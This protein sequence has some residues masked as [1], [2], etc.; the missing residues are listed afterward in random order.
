M[1]WFGTHFLI[2]FGGGTALI[3][4]LSYRYEWLLN[5]SMTIAFASGLWAVLPD[6]KDPMAMCRP[7]K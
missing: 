5:W 3:V 7:L 1:V 6:L 2:G 4:L